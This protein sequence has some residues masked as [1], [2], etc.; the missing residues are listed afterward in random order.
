MMHKF[1]IRTVSVAGFLAAA[2]VGWQMADMPAASHRSATAPIRTRTTERPVAAEPSPAAVADMDALRKSD[3]F[4]GRMRG[5]IALADSISLSDIPAWLDGAWFD[6]GDGYEIKLF[7]RILTDRLEASQPL[8]L[9]DLSP[10]AQLERYLKCA[11]GGLPESEGSMVESK[12]LFRLLA[13]VDP[14]ALEAVLGQLMIPERDYAEEALL[15]RRLNDS[16]DT[17]IRKLWARPDGWHAFKSFSGNVE[18]LTKLLANPAALPVSW[19]NS[20]AAESYY[21]RIDFD[22][23]EFWWNVD[24]EAAGFS[25]AQVSVIRKDALDG[26]KR[27]NPEMA[28]AVMEEI[29]MN[30]ADRKE[31][32]QSIFARGGLTETQAAK[33]LESLRYDEDWQAAQEQLARKNRPE[34]PRPQQVDR[35]NQWLADFTKLEPQ[36]DDARNY[37]NMLNRWDGSQLHDLTNQLRELP[38][39]TK[40]QTAEKLARYWGRGT[41]ERQPQLYAEAIRILAGAKDGDS[42]T[43]RSAT[44]FALEWGS[45]DPAAASE[46]ITNLPAGAAKISARNGLAVRWSQLD[47]AAAGAWVDSLPDEDRSQVRKILQAKSS[48]SSLPDEKRAP[49]GPKNH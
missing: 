37:R 2:A 40:I 20:M 32:I 31:F 42:K 43:V 10:E 8:V 30:D 23:A 45:A 28:I 29:A 27:E 16:F 11:A 7:T 44:F 33:L 4:A 18:F 15:A 13:E 3:D 35:P 9:V 24:L 17:E 25:P 14:E 34:P 21:R 26:I 19:R 46:W 47:P 48:E 36:S 38:A 1:P 39:D 12:E 49:I 41:I 5:T 6:P 22:T